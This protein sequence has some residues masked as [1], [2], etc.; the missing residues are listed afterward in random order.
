MPFGPYKD[1]DECIKDNSNK[2]KPEAYCAVIHKNITDKWP[3]EKK[4]M[5]SNEIRKI[6]NKIIAGIDQTV[7]D[8]EIKHIIKKNLVLSKNPILKKYHDSD[9]P[10]LINAIYDELPNNIK[11][12]QAQIIKKQTEDFINEFLCNHTREQFLRIY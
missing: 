3:G 2:D 10:K 6:A 1:F 11:P 9:M 5:K 7:D 4:S 12:D 8:P